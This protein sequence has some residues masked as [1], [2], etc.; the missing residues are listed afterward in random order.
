MM[1]V[2]WKNSEE[3]ADEA[4]GGEG[5]RMILD[6]V[7]MKR[8]DTGTIMEMDMRMI[9]GEGMMSGM[10]VWMIILINCK[11]KRSNRA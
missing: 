5:M 2:L 1:T 8:M 9:L 11:E 6:L 10:K 4:V 3:P 7:R